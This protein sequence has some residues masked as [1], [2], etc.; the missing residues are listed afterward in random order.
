MFINLTPHTI[1]IKHDDNEITIDPSGTIAR[2]NV[3][4]SLCGTIEG[5]PVV[6][7][8]TGGVEGIPATQDD[9]YY[10]TSS[11]V[12]AATSRKDVLAP[13]TGPT[14]IRKEGRIVAVTRLIH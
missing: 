9:V 8:I 11:M 14:C 4:E 2:V 3:E 7:R 5:I 6:H 13:D 12:K 1:K 10:I